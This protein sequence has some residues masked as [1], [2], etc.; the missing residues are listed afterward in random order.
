[1]IPELN[2]TSRKAELKINNDFL[3]NCVCMH[4]YFQIHVL[5]REVSTLKIYCNVLSFYYIFIINLFL[6]RLTVQFCD[7]THSSET[8]SFP[9]NAVFFFLKI[10]TLLFNKDLIVNEHTKIKKKCN[11][12]RHNFAATKH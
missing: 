1:M 6:N 9:K 7:F 12:F 2:K 4:Q 11:I 3:L 5:S 8:Y 10:F